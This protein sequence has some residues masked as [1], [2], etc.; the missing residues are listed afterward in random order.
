MVIAWNCIA[1][2]MN[3]ANQMRSPY[4]VV[5][6]FRDDM[7]DFSIDSIVY[8]T[9]IIFAYDSI[10][11]VIHHEKILFRVWFALLFHV[12]VVGLAAFAAVVM[13]CSVTDCGLSG[14]GWKA[15]GGLCGER[16]K[17]RRPIL[18]I[19][20]KCNSVFYGMETIQP[21][22]ATMVQSRSDREEHMTEKV[23]FV[24]DDPN[25]LVTFRASFR[26]KFDLDLAEGPAEALEKLKSGQ[27][28]A[29]IVS[30][31]KMPG[32]SGMDFLGLAHKIAPT[33][34]RIMLTGHGD[35]SLAMDAVNRG[36][37][38]RFLQKPCPT[39]DLE[40]AVKA[41][42]RQHRLM[43]S[44]KV[45]LRQTLKGTVE[46]L[47]EIVSL[48]NP[49]A[50]GRSQRIKR[51]MTALVEVMGIGNAWIY[52]L[53]GMLSQLGCILLPESALAKLQ[54]GKPL[55]G[56]EIQLFE[57][58]PTLGAELLK[59]I[60]RLAKVA[61]MVAY[62]E[63]NYDGTGI[64]PDAVKEET[65]P[66]GAR[67]LKLVL[68]YDTALMRRKKP[69]AAFA[70]LEEHIERYDPE[71]LYYLEG[72]LGKAAHYTL[73]DMSITELY[74]G[75][76]LDETVSTDDGVVVCRKS[77]EVTASMIAKLKAF[78]QRSPIRQP[79]KVLVPENTRTCVSREIASEAARGDEEAKR[80]P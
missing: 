62:Q 63:K 53:A 69:S 76:I 43:M 57:M 77:M 49:E 52:E 26:K 79:F 22:N 70:D 11:F 73:K 15:G 48:V 16:T 66:L 33:S 24:D 12:S 58:H 65:I 55:E 27:R 5:F 50:F 30:D 78:Q 4:S 71:L 10:L 13:F 31:Q 44:E 54:K 7:A 1:I 56:E 39:D 37:L 72:C 35:F 18:L 21:K 2:L 61:E 75:I 6:V 29:V 80:Q 42:L 19:I 67:M 40:R 38:F 60:P 64:P 23:L 36:Q 51:H 14:T 68:D 17:Y 20:P 41:G 47:T 9:T 46:L 45:V 74:P 32:M 34:V 59:K 28:Y 3:R 25:I 8:E